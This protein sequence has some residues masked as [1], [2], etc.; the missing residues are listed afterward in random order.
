[1]AT[2]TPLPRLRILAVARAILPAFCVDCPP[3]ISNIGLHPAGGAVGS[4]VIGQKPNICPVPSRLVDMAINTDY[5]VPTSVFP[6]ENPMRF[7]R[8]SRRSLGPFLQCTACKTLAA[9]LFVAALFAQTC[10][11]Q[12]PGSFDGCEL[13]GKTTNPSLMDLN[14]L[15]NRTVAPLKSQVNPAISLTAVLA[16]GN[17]LARWQPTQAAIITGYVVDVQPGGPETVNCQKTDPVHADTH[18][19]IALNAGDSQGIHHMIVEVTPRGRAIMA[20]KGKDWSTKNLRKTLL[21][22]KITVVGWM[23]LDKEHCNAAENT[24]PGHAKNWRAT[25]WE[26]HPVSALGPAQ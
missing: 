13:Q 1:M 23:M 12:D 17:D 14:R 10:T 20:S 2:R 19:E 11:A 21:G 25:C 4:T 18:I 26:I 24:N 16:P 5:A 8:F 15:K 9:P 7:L 3:Y 6:T 22:H